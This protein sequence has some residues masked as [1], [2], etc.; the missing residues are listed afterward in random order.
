MICVSSVLSAV[1]GLWHSLRVGKI[2]SMTSNLKEFFNLTLTY[3]LNTF[4]TIFSNYKQLTTTN[5]V[6]MDIR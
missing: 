4:N 3:C 1:K 5:K 2:V 6:A